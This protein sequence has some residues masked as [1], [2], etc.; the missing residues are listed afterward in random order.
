ME[1]KQA[2]DLHDPVPHPAWCDRA[3]CTATPSATT[4]EVHRSA[5]ISVVIRGP[6]SQM[7]VT[8][9]L[10]Q[11]HAPWLTSVLIQLDV[12]GVTPDTSETADDGWSVSGT[13]TMSLEGAAELTGLL[14]DLVQQ[15]TQDWDRYACV[16]RAWRDVRGLS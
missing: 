3:A 6:M 15:A 12:A 14:G 4:G 2:C 1:R 11:A 7:T 9:W 8:G 10:V 16:H 5:M 13:V